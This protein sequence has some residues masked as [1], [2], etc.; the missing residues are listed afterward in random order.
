MRRRSPCC[1]AAETRAPCANAQTNAESHPNTSSTPASARWTH[2]WS[3]RTPYCRFGGG[4]R[5]RQA[6]WTFGGLDQ[7]EYWIDALRIPHL[8]SDRWDT[9]NSYLL[10]L[11]EFLVT[12]ADRLLN[13]YHRYQPI[14]DK[15]PRQWME[16]VL[17]RGLRDEMR[18]RAL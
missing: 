15:E 10:E 16:T 17:M 6:A 13:G 4:R 2:P 8:I 9:T 3:P 1:C 14:Q 7:H 18:T 11:I 12:H 5:P